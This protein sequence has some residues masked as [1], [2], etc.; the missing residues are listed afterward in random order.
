M[1]SARP[2]AL[3]PVTVSIHTDV[4]VLL[5]PHAPP[6]VDKLI[7]YVNLDGRVNAFYSTPAI[8]TQALYDAGVNWTVKVHPLSA[9]LVLVPL[10]L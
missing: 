9:A 6:T 1:C 7:H 8:F 10:V 3:E 5:C 4:W 2:S